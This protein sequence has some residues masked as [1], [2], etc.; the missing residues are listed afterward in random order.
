LINFNVIS[1]NAVQG[2]AKLA[3]KGFY[4]E[5]REKLVKFSIIF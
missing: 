3:Q 4:K 5:A 1:A 2:S